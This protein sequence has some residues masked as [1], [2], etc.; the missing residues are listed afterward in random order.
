MKPF[1]AVT[2]ALGLGAGCTELSTDVPSRGALDVEPCDAWTVADPIYVWP[3]DHSMRR[4]TLADCV[5][6]VASECPP[7]TGSTCGDSVVDPGEECDDGNLN[8]FDGCD[9]CILTDPN[10][11][12]AAPTDAALTGLTVTSITSNEAADATG[13]GRTPVDA[14]IVDAT[15]FELRAERDGSRGGRTYS[16]DFV[17]T[18]GETGACTFIVPHDLATL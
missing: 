1:V 15:T 12:V 17:D 11:D 14:V 18:N 5:A 2:L 16:V 3:P 9:Q 4:Y 7:P 6:V 8:P 10:P 13:D